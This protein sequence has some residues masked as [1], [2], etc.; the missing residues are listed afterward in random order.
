MRRNAVYKTLT[1]STDDQIAPATTTIQLNG[2]LATER[3]TPRL[4]IRAARVAFGH[5][6]RVTV[7]DVEAGIGY[8]L[9]AKSHRKLRWD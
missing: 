3:L 8:R 2:V 7:V 5:R 6:N 9:Y 1:V 4:A